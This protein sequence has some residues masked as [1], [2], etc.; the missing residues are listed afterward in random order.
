MHITLN[1]PVRSMDVDTKIETVYRG[2]E[3]V[4]HTGEVAIHRVFGETVDAAGKSRRRQWH[5]FRHT[6]RFDFL[7][8]RPVLRQALAHIERERVS[9][10]EQRR[11]IEAAL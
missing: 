8:T 5:N 1:P 9:L 11:V 7:L 3:L 4:T 2:V 10:D 6:E